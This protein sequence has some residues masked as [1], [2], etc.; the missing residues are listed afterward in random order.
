VEHAKRATRSASR[1]PGSWG[2]G[3]C[4]WH[5]GNVRRAIGDDDSAIAGFTECRELG[6]VH[7]YGIAEMVACND[8]G[9]IWEA[10]G[11]LDTARPILERALQLRRELGAVRLGSVHGTMPTA[12]LAVAR[13]AA[14]QGD[15]ATTSALLREGLPLAEEMREAETAAAMA[16]LLRKLTQADTTRRAMLRPENGTWHIEFDGTERARARPE[17]AVAPA[18]AARPAAP[19]G[20]RALAHGRVE[21]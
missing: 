10:R 16:A 4:A 15:L 18:L 6:R 7:G 17:G 20:G 3:F 2:S 9:K 19:A 1:H 12:L 11:A 8:L 21:R 14:Q 5:L 13:V